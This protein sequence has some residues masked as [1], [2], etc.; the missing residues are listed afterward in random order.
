MNGAHLT[1]YIRSPAG[2][3]GPLAAGVPGQIAGLSFLEEKFGEKFKNEYALDIDPIRTVGR[4][5]H[6]PVE[7]ANLPGE[8]SPSTLQAATGGSL[9]G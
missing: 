2:P 9:D 7:E 8:P 1:E 5:G 6:N 4:R 3:H